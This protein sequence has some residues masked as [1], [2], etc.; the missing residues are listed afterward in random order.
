[1]KR[2][3]LLLISVFLISCSFAQCPD[4]NYAMINSCG[5][6]GDEGNNE[7]VVFTTSQMDTVSHFTFNYGSNNPPSSGAS[8]ILAGSD[9]GAKT[10]TG[11]ISSTVGTCPIIEITSPDSVIPA[12]S[13]VIFIPA[14]FNQHYD[15]TGLCNGNSPIYVVYILT[16]NIGGTNSNWTSG[17]TLANNN[18]TPRYLQVTESGICS[19]ISA[20]VKSYTASGNWPANSDGNFVSWNGT[21]TI[22]G[23]NGCNVIVLPLRFIGIKAVNNKNVNIVNW[24]TG[25][26]INVLNFVVEKSYDS[27]NFQPI[28]TIDITSN[29][30]ITNS[31]QYTDNKIQNKTTYYRVKSVDIDGRFLYSKIAVVN[32]SSLMIKGISVYP[33]PAHDKL[34]VQWESLN[35][36]GDVFLSIIDITGKVIQKEVISSTK[37]GSNQKE[38]N[39]S[40]LP[41]GKYIIQMK[42]ESDVQSVSFSK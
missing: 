39:V 33:N 1:M 28:G 17:G 15:V 13:R 12:N 32:A 41:H 2:L 37:I 5:I 38:L 34:N 35:I 30:G 18:S 10:D 4:I 25:D 27:R 11:S 16:N 3:I 23:N 40:K 7:F 20:P 31:Y 29:R 36:S 19:D 9:A 8:N 26:E 24:Q 21:D 42:S 14:S 22:Y 6:G